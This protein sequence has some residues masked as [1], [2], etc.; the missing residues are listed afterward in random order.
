ME[1]QAVVGRYR[2]KF[3]V[4][5]RGLVGFLVRWPERHP[6]ASFSYW[7]QWEQARLRGYT[8]PRHP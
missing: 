1:V 6:T 8:K 7:R 5:R 2:I 4:L 3:L